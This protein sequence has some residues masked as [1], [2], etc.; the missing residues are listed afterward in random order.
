TEARIILVIFNLGVVTASAA[1]LDLRGTLNVAM[2]GI[3]VLL[4]VG[5]AGIM[6][7]RF[8]KN[9]KT[10]AALEPAVAAPRRPLSHP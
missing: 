9:M 6:A 10:L 7:A 4:G 3:G 5:M 8:V 1:G 2:D